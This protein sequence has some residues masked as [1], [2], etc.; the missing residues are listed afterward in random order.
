MPAARG[1]LVERRD[2]MADRPLA[3]EEIAAL[4]SQGCSAENWSRVRVKDPF[5]ADRVAQVRFSGEVRLGAMDGEV[6]L[7]GGLTL[8]C[9]IS[10]CTVHN[11]RIGDGAYLSHVGCLANYDIG[12]GVVIDHVGVLAV[13]GETA[14]GNGTVLA[15]LNEAGGRELKIFDRLSAPI[16]Y[17]LVLYRHEAAMRERL[18]ALI[19]AYVAARRSR[20]GRVAAGSR[21]EHCTRLTNVAV[22]PHAVISGAA[23]LVDGSVVGCPEDPAVIGAGVTARHFIV[24]AGS[25]VD[26]GAMLDRCFIGQGVRI[27]KQFSAENSAFFANCEG[28]HGEACSIFAGPYT[29]THHKS[30]LLIASLLSFCNAGSGT[31]QSNHMYKLGPV[32]QGVMMRGAK[33]GSFSYLL[34]PSRVGAFSV[35]VGKHMSA[36]DAANLPFSY[37]Q[38]VQERTV[39]TPAMNLFTVGTVRDA[40][41][42]PER[43][44]RRTTDRLDL[45][46]F[47]LFTPA[48]VDRA[49]RGMDDLEALEARTPKARE[50][51]MYRGAQIPRILLK[52]ACRHYQ[53]VKSIFMGD[54]LSE[55]LRTAGSPDAVRRRLAEL[56]GGAPG[57]WADLAG[58]LAPMA[59]VDALCRQIAEGAV[60][61]LAALQ[62]KLA[63][64]HAAYPEQKLRWFAALLRARESVVPGEI[65]NAQMAGILTEWRDARVKLN[66]LILF[67]AKKEFDVTCRIGFGI[68]GDDAV[69]DQDFEAVRGRYEDS[70]FVRALVEETGRVQAQADELIRLL[71]P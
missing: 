36:F 57:P 71:T 22:G 49:L 23:E 14:F 44:R 34:W 45:I 33:T 70:K 29:V 59:V 27:G 65:T 41:K 55:L 28:F 39:I 26:G 9:G 8:P 37:I 2:S 18:E 6:R 69:R 61:D 67:D 13:E 40:A 66:T 19:D 51:A 7:P 64:I 52:K 1:N 47:D 50:F 42:W 53:M 32:H 16:A 60:A 11:C 48:I 58:L 17:L 24:L 5:R 31:N 4:E 68:D 43:D 56:A 54:C 46:H 10:R 63:E 21:I 62:S 20:R 38:A 30:T 25:H 15:I 3:P 35:V 12:D